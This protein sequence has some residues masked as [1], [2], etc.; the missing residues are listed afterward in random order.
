MSPEESS[1][2]ES[3]ERSP[4]SGP[5]IG[6]GVGFVLI[7]AVVGGLIYSSRNSARNAVQPAVS[8]AAAQ[9]DPYATKLQIGDV[10]LSQMD[11]MI[12]GT[13]TYIEGTVIN[14]G[15]K[16]VTGATIEV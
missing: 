8:G 15:E 10:H 11:N 13:V 14:A 9:A 2:R 1:S 5:W 7:A 12:G 3:E 6:L 16:T 4:M